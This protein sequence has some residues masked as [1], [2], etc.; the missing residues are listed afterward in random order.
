MKESDRIAKTVELLASF[1]V[2][3]DEHP[4][5][6]TV[7]GRANSPLVAGRI[8]ASRPSNRNVRGTHEPH[9]TRRDDHRRV[10]RPEF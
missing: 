5:G 7:H 6:L 10:E 9:C 4:D 3:V 2:S 1:G 8:D